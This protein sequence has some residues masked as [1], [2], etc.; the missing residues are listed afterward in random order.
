MGQGINIR[1]LP[2]TGIPVLGYPVPLDRVVITMLTT[3]P[4]R[5]TPIRI[6]VVPSGLLVLVMCDFASTAYEHRACEPATDF[7]Y[8][9]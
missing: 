5:S 4:Q 9:E 3:A 2:L 7:E 1:L 6:R 8:S